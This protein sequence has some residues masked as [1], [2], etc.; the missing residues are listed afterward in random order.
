MSDLFHE[1][2]PFEFIRRVFMRMR[3]T[4]QHTYQILTKRPKVAILFF[5]EMKNRGSTIGY[6]IL[7]NVWVGVSVE[8]QQTADERI[9]LLRHI[10]ASV[11]FLSCEP[12]LG[13]IDLINLRNGRS[14]AF[15]PGDAGINWV[16][17]GGESGP[18][19]R[20][21]H[22]D[23][24]RSIRDQCAAAGVP[25]FFKQWGEWIP[26]ADIAD[27]FDKPGYIMDC[28]GKAVEF[29]AKG[30]MGAAGEPSPEMTYF[31]RVGKKKAGNI[32]F[33][34]QHLEYPK[35]TI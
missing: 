18:G 8:D 24:A 12:L 30:N 35:P 1:D 31:V 26:Y 32:L 15:N 2:V 22:P 17:C 7:Q 6:D 29:E 19:A 13:H 33:G 9:P 5:E 23:W 25:F 34:R 20:P 28:T 4:P 10:P 21:M 3:N 16:I 11:K 27:A 14:D